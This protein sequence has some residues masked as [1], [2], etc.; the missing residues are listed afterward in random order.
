VT[1]GQYVMIAVT[2]TGVGMTPEQVAR[3][4]EPFYTTKPDGS[5]TGLG[6]SMVYG[7]ARQSGGHFTLYSEPGHGTTA[8]LYIPRSDVAPVRSAPE[9]RDTPMA[10]GE[11][12]LVVEDDPSVRATVWQAL[13][14]LGYR[15]L[16][17]DSA[18]AALAL[19]RSG[20][21]PDLLFTDV[22]MPGRPTA[23]DL[24]LEAVQM[25]DGHLAVV[26]TSGYTENAIVHNGQLDAGVRLVS[27]PWRVDQLARALRAAIDAM[28]PR[29]KL[30]RGLRVLLVEDEMLV[31][32]TSAELL[33]DMGHEVE[34]AASGAEALQMLEG[35]VDVLI[36]DLGLP[37][38]NGAELIEAA[39]RRQ[40]ALAVVVATGRNSHEVSID[41]PCVWLAKPY[42]GEGLRRALTEAMSPVG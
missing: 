3:A 29:P 27:K 2:D 18:A 28:P 39:R 12:V 13:Q 34:T 33:A 26:F 11:L 20:A 24:A 19:L 42:D 1:P 22:V 21:R 38:M 35:G 37:D 15:V 16:V 14:E 9:R 31:S 8:R 30:S 32:M 40:E 6:L 7:F 25:L 5:G 4:V 41:G 23:R 10:S 36:T 17:A